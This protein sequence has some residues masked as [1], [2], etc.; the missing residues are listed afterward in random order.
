MG[1]SSLVISCGEVLR[2]HGHR[3]L[4]VVS[5]NDAVRQWAQQAGLEWIHPAADYVSF[6]RRQPFDHLFSIVNHR[7]LP[8]EALTAARKLAI[9]FHDSPLPLYAGIHATTWAIA[10]GEAEHGVSWHVM[11]ETTDAGDV[12]QS[13]QVTLTPDETS[14]SL[15]LKCYEAALASFR[16]LIARLARGVICP[17]AQ[18]RRMRTYF[19]RHAKPSPACVMSWNRSAT[20]LQSLVR[21]CDFGTLENTFGAAKMMLGDR[22]VLVRAA[23][24]SESSS[25]QSPGTILDI[26]QRGLRIATSD[27]AILLMALTD[28]FGNELPVDKLAESMG[29]VRGQRLICLGESMAAEAQR[30]LEGVYRA[31][32]A[33]VARLASAI[34][35]NP[36]CRRKSATAASATRSEGYRRTSMEFPA[37]CQ[38]NL[39]ELSIAFLC[40]M[41]SESNLCI[42]VNVEPAAGSTVARAVLASRVPLELSFEDRSET[43]DRFLPRIRA[44]LCDVQQRP[45]HLRDIHARYPSLCKARGGESTWRMPMTVERVSS[46]DAIDMRQLREDGVEL[47]LCVA[48]DG[49]HTTWLYDPRSVRADDVECLALQF[50]TFVVNAL[51]QPVARLADV[52]LM[53]DDE[54]RKILLTWN[55]TARPLPRDKCVHE[56]VDEQTMRSPNAIA[57]TFGDQTLSYGELQRKSRVLAGQ[58]KEKGLGAGHFVGVCMDRSL[59][60]PAA[61]LGV[62][63]AGAAYIPLDPTHPRSRIALMIQDSGLSA[64][65]VDASLVPTL[66][67]CDATLIIPDFTANERSDGVVAADARQPSPDDIAYMIYTSGSTGTPKGVPIRHASVVNLLTSMQTTPGMAARDRILALT[68]ISFDI[69]CVELFLPVICGASAEILSA[70]VA[71]DGVRL[72]KTL[73]TSDA[74]I[75]QATPATWRLLL[76]AG[77][78]GHQRIRIWCGGEALPPHL[79]RQLLERCAELWNCYGPTEAT[80][81]ACFQKVSDPDEIAIGRPVANTQAYILDAQ[82]RPV[83]VGVSGELYL[84]GQGLSPGYHRRPDLNQ[85]SFLRNPFAAPLSAE[86]GASRLYR[87][88]DSCRFWP[89][90]RIEYL[91]RLDSQIKIRG[92]RVELGEI[93]SVLA[94]RSDVREAVVTVVN[95]EQGNKKLVAYIVPSSPGQPPAT[96]DLRKYLHQHLP[97]YMIPASFPLIAYI[98]LSPNGKVDRN[99]LS[100]VTA[101]PPRAPTF[102]PTVNDAHR[103]VIAIWREFLKSSEIGIHDNF[104]DV[105]GDSILLVQLA[106]RLSREYGREIMTLELFRFPT[107]A[108]FADYITGNAES[109]AKSTAAPPSVRMARLLSR[110]ERTAE[111]LQRK[112]ALKEQK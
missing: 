99:S 13:G 41:A 72:R 101:L 66:P 28:E 67:P 107:V 6:L 11:N 62:L 91:G 40:R 3:I 7:K 36:P 94:R 8:A 112:Q 45:S 26:S 38:G 5:P 12:L 15:N 61:L 83:P 58:L 31:E 82:L 50:Q 2:D 46:L 103:R 19:A 1:D 100:S 53:T 60:L 24:V 25:R 10:R 76:A 69:A 47:A 56:L 102:D 88:G 21:A 96:E 106:Q 42:G 73:E 30:D 51:A 108:A 79:A 17:R 63:K 78:T 77:W 59:D 64:V 90:G 92:F 105:G 4:G 93:E 81:Y 16:E 9:N 20:E 29:L 70:D 65:L 32:A 43:L 22:C 44:A 14:H 49:A 35:S 110:T 23:E 54:T 95:D 27:S 68:T 18:D 37:A 97:A 33:W 98:P 84:A 34:P 55:D 111:R 52:P 71:T 75:V 109:T 85:K 80:V 89:D 39:L 87:T 86:Q 74:S 57:Y 104:F 48:N